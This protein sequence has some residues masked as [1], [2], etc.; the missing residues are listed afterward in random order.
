MYLKISQKEE[1]LYIANYIKSNN[2]DSTANTE[3]EYNYLYENLIH[4]KTCKILNLS[5]F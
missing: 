5:Y 4:D 2:S 1:R 3:P